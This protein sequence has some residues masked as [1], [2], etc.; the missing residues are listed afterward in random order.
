[1]HFPNFKGT[2]NCSIHYNW[3]CLFLFFCNVIYVSYIFNDRKKNA[4]VK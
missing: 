2:S 3:K 1:M 4:K